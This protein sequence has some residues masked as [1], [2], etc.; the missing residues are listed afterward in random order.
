MNPLATTHSGKSGDFLT[1]T[2]LLQLTFNFTVF[3]NIP[4]ARQVVAFFFLTFVPGYIIVKL[5]KITKFNMT[6]T[7]IFSVGFSIAF[8]IIVGSLVN[9]LCQLGIL[10]SF[11]LL[12]LTIA[13]NCFISLGSIL[14]Y[15]KK[16]EF[17]SLSIETLKLAPST[18][19]LMILPILSIVG[20]MYV[21]LYGNNKLLLF[22]IIL[23]SLLF[24]IGL[25][26]DKLSHLRLYSLAVL[27]IAISLL[28][29]ASLISNY[30][31]SFGSDSPIE[32]YIFKITENNRYWRSVF[33]YP[34]DTGYSR[35]NSMLSVTILPYIYLTFL[36]MDATWVFKI[37]Y[38][39][40]FSLVPLAFYELLRK[41]F[42]E[43]KAFIA[44]FLFMAQNVFYTEMLGL[45][46]QMIAELFF[47]LLLLVIL[48]KK[49]KTFTKI[50]SFTIFS[51]ALITSH[52][53]LAEIFLLFVTTAWISL[54][55]MK[56]PSRK[57]TITM[58]ALFFTTMFLWYLYTSNSAVFS[59]FVSFG[60]YV[61]DQ[62]NQFFNLGARQKTV[63]MGLGLEPPPTIWNMFSRVFA[64]LT[65]FLIV[66]GFVELIVNRKESQVEREQFIFTII[67][68]A[69]LIALI[70]VP[71]LANTM[72]MTRFYHILLF[73]LAPM[74]VLGAELIGRLVFKRRTKL[75]ASTLLLI[76][77]VPY[78]LFQ[79]GLIYELTGTQSW[80]LP[81]S[82]YR[83]NAI[84]LRGRLG[85]FDE[86]EILST[87]WLSENIEAVKSKVYA[88]AASIDH[89][90]RSYGMIYGGNTEILLNVTVLSSDGILFLNKANTIDGVA[91]GSDL[92]NV[93]Y[94][95]PVLD[96]INIMYSNGY[97]EIYKN[98]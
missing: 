73:F 6:E 41:N 31:V 95:S 74:C 81:L 26:S 21:N 83:M 70:V 54:Y 55:L 85:Y 75:L 89:I 49:L 35:I 9:E 72:N 79:T 30:L 4:V 93:T 62:L 61:L 17:E 37:V 96:S 90:L 58:V 57:I 20:A 29:H 66:V 68:V 36:N 42:G 2:L 77:L 71:G 28:F 67:A 38:P 64:Y 60:S 14:I 88:D 56:R 76:V 44:V 12:P 86:C 27:M 91:L 19:F 22:L 8:L 39:L 25:L 16:G 24:T 97:C 45:N 78:F 3:I 80:S 63:L 10:Y 87:F 32:Y 23:I 98:R 82:K 33:I 15:L 40:I 53:A 18:I 92:W 47:I 51:F 69:F 65:E 5:L 46:R 52:Y 34:W 59:S 84:F 50:V 43:K 7:L 11:S 13:V 94:I 1:I 48:N